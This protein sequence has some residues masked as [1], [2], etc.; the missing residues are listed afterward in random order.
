MFQRISL[1]CFAEKE[2]ENEINVHMPSACTY[3]HIVSLKFQ[4][5]FVQLYL[6][7]YTL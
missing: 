5:C 1:L 6:F 3:V 7:I 2:M 4:C